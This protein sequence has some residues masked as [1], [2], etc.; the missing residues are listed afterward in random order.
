MT[1]SRKPFS[2]LIKCQPG[3]SK[4]QVLANKRNTYGKNLKNSPEYQVGAG[5]PSWK[6]QP[7][8][9]SH[10]APHFYHKALRCLSFDLALDAHNKKGIEGVSHHFSTLRRP[11]DIS[12]RT[13]VGRIEINSIINNI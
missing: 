7:V 4:W 12:L 11:K 10:T 8:E 9:I 1:F 2:Q 6:L 5:A 13:I 3:K